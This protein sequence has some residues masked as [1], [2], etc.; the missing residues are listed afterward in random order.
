MA[1]TFQQ[2]SVNCEDLCNNQGQNPFKFQCY[3]LVQEADDILGSHQYVSYD[4]LS[5][6]SYTNLAMKETLLLRASA[7]GFTQV[8]NKDGELGHRIPAGTLINI[9]VFTLHNSLKYLDDPGNFNP[10]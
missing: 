4:D 3:K 9:G 7:P 6:L 5:K 10:E 8:M 1:T 2:Y